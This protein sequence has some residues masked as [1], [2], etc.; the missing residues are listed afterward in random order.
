MHVDK[1]HTKFSCERWQASHRDL[2]LDSENRNSL[3][4]C[5]FI[6]IMSYSMKVCHNN[7]YNVT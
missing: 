3:T 6:N 2:Y 4:K 1:Y 7:C 5:Q